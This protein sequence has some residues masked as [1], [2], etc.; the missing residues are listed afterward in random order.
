[1]LLCSLAVE[2]FA[3]GPDPVPMDVVSMLR[4]RWTAS[5]TGSL[6]ESEDATVRSAIG[7]ADAIAKSKWTSMSV[8]PTSLWSDLTPLSSD[9]DMTM[10]FSRLEYLAVAY[11]TPGSSFYRLIPARHAQTV[12]G[13]AQ[14]RRVHVGAPS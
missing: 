2:G 10:T 7:R 13:L 8:S 12:T 1:M 5:L 14:W 11:R 6:I 3:T 4:A 9:S